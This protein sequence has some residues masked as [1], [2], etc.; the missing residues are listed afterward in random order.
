[1]TY[2][3][4]EDNQ[5][6]YPHFGGLFVLLLGWTQ[7]PQW[8]CSAWTGR[9]R[10]DEYPQTCAELADP[11]LRCFQMCEELSEFGFLEPGS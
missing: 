7:L 2:D 9:H 8:F 6:S 3:I 5:S 11:P 1:M 10:D 4:A